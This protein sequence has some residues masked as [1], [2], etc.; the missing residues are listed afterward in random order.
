M[1]SELSWAIAPVC[2]VIVV[3]IGGGIVAVLVW[4]TSG[5]SK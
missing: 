4:L 1:T 5:K 2:G 3:I